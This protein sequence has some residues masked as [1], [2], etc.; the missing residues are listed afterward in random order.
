MLAHCSCRIDSGPPLR[1]PLLFLFSV[2]WYPTLCFPFSKVWQDDSICKN[3]VRQGAVAAAD[4]V[5]D[6]CIL[7]D[8]KASPS[9]L[10]A[11]NSIG[12]AR[13]HDMASYDG[14]LSLRVVAIRRDTGRDPFSMEHLDIWTRGNSILDSFFVGSLD[15]L[16]PTKTL[17]LSGT[18][19]TRLPVVPAAYSLLQHRGT[20]ALPLDRGRNIGNIAHL[21]C[22][23]LCSNVSSLPSTPRSFPNQDEPQRPLTPYL[24]SRLFHHPFFSFLG[25]LS[26]HVGGA[27][28][29]SNYQM[30]L[31]R[32][33]PSS[34]G[35]LLPS[36]RARA[37]YAIV[38]VY[39]SVSL[40]S[41][42]VG[43]PFSFTLHPVAQASFPFCSLR[44][45]FL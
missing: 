26:R 9:S 18:I 42:A 45:T 3:A 29:G 33:L 39:I 27:V 38:F 32:V 41:F 15:R 34:P 5:R 16:A 11:V 1:T 28:V 13:P 2:F 6:S 35:L 4:I 44:T 21:Y 14:N 22:G 23:V 17:F 12:L 30:L 24:G 8:K 37:T 19:V 20:S 31:G 7:Q 36:Q 40:A 10:M 43:L 25:T